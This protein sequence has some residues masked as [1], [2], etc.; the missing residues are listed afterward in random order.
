[1]EHALD[2][3]EHSWNTAHLMQVLSLIAEEIED[4]RCHVTSGESQNSL[5]VLFT[6]L[7]Y[8]NASSTFFS[9]WASWFFM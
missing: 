4:W 2:S 7:N 3:A 8:R 5:K 1:M 6:L 9:S